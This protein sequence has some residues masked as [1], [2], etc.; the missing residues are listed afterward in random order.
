MR[1]LNLR[2]GRVITVAQRPVSVAHGAQAVTQ[3]V[4]Q[5]PE[6]QALVCESDHA[7]FGAL[8]E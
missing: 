8:M 2:D 3:L 1:E 5:W 6:A 4:E 7:A